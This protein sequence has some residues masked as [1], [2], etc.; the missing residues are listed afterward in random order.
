[1]GVP[2]PGIKSRQQLQPTPQLQRSWILDPLC[3]SGSFLIL[4]SWR[5]ES[6]FIHLLRPSAFR[7]FHSF[8]DTFKLVSINQW[9]CVRL[10]ARCWQYKIKLAK[11]PSIRMSCFWWKSK[12][13]SFPCGLLGPAQYL[14]YGD[15][16]W[17]FDT[18]FWEFWAV[19][20]IEA[21]WLI[22]WLLQWFSR[23]IVKVMG[24]EQCEFQCCFWERMNISMNISGS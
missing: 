10:L 3:H 11:P 24:L 16:Q 19:E 22:K 6:G 12:M 1:M 21:R 4:L 23:D 8:T 13:S 7:T 14:D 2:E 15:P 20:P 17:M 18:L 9:W 5:Q